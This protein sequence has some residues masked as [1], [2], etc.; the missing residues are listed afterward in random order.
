MGQ[1]V[2]P[3]GFRVGVNKN[4]DSVWFIDKK[5][6]SKSM[7]EDL[8]IKKIL[9]DFNYSNDA[10]KNGKKVAAEISKVEIYRKPDRLTV[11]INSSR[12]GIVIGQEGKNIQELTKL[13]SKI[14]SSKIDI[15]IKDLKKPETN[16]MLIAQGIAKQLSARIPFR[17]AMKKAI[18]DAK[19]AGVNGI[20]IQCAG[21]LGGADMARTEWY[22]EGRI[23]LQTLRA[24]IDYGYTVAN[25]TYGI[26]GVKVWVFTKEILK[27]DIKEDA[28]QLVKKQKKFA[29]K[30]GDE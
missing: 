22:R 9:M 21:R 27:K 20:K 16:A 19:K 26:I 8:K 2:N 28:G 14:T 24:D 18:S 23:P 29:G 7:H 25:T 10:K 5:G 15:K 3:I 1:K 17:R 13:I 12:P 11:Y 6:Y 4:W 30:K